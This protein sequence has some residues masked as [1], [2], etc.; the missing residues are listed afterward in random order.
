MNH[1]SRGKK[2]SAGGHA[3]H[4]DVRRDRH[5]ARLSGSRAVVLSR[6]AAAPSLRDASPLT[7]HPAQLAAGRARAS[8][9]E[10][11]SAD[12]DTGQV[13]VRYR[14]RQAVVHYAGAAAARVAALR[15]P[16]APARRRASSSAVAACAAIAR[17]RRRLRADTRRGQDT[18]AGGR[19]GGVAGGRSGTSSARSAST[20][21]G[22]WT[23]L[24][25]HGGAGRRGRQ[26][27]RRRHRRGLR[28]PRRRTA[29]RPTCRPSACVPATTSSPTIRYPNDRQRPRDVRRQSRS[30]RPPTTTSAWSGV[31]YGADIMPVRVLDAAR[32]GDLGGHRR[33]A[34]ATPSTTARGSSTSRSSSSTCSAG[35]PYIDHE[36]ARR[37][38]RDPLRR[39]APACPSWSPRGNSGEAESRRRVLDDSIIYVGGHDRA[40]LPRRLLE[41]RPRRRPRRARAA[42]ATRALPDDPHCAPDA[43]AGRN[44]QQVSFKRRPVR[45]LLDLARSQRAHRAEGHVDGGAPRH[46]R[47]R[48]A[49]RAR[50]CSASTRRPKQIAQRADRR[51]RATSVRRG[52]IATTPPASSTR[53]PRCAARRS[54]R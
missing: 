54:A 26:G 15:R 43:K 32:R 1:S 16:A 38:R 11:R 28:Q 45:R 33:A 7:A 23:Q 48:A 35:A 9:R 40:R 4:L 12:L 5:G 36:L 25:A 42:A 27:R 44:V 24:A 41:L 31:A 49:A 17:P 18:A 52:P 37:P 6:R 53:P 3:H 30:P 10:R 47:R 13:V 14:G 21:P 34:S 8:T 20:S 51:P 22:A 46:R 2:R 29:A 50:R 19:R 39:R